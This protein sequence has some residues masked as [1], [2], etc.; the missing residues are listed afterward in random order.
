MLPLPGPNNIQTFIHHVTDPSSISKSQFMKKGTKY[1]KHLIY[2]HFN[3]SK[4]TL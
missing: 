2:H 4:F 3:I 1:Y